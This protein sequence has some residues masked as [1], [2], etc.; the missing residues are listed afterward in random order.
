MYYLSKVLQFKSYIEHVESTS[1]LVLIEVRD[2][3]KSP[4]DANSFLLY[5]AKTM[6][7]M[8]KWGRR[9]LAQYSYRVHL[10]QGDYAY[11]QKLYI[12]FFMSSRPEKKEKYRVLSAKEDTSETYNMMTIWVGKQNILLKIRLNISNCIFFQYIF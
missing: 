1:R 4:T 7:K 6:T 9:N 10:F 12:F 8:F 2:P 5:D 11:K 3:T